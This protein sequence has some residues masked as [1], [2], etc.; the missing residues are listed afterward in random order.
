MKPRIA[1]FFT[2]GT[3][4][5]AREA[6]DGSAVPR[7]SGSDIAA[8]IP[9]LSDRFELTAFEFGRFPGPHMTGQRVRELRG[10]IEEALAGDQDGVVVSHGTDTIEETA[11]SLDL[12]HRSEKPAVVVGAMRTKD[13]PSWDGP[14]NLL[15]ACLTAGSDVAKNLGTLIV[16]NRTIHAASEAT[17]T[18]TGSLDA[19]VSPECGPLG[20]VDLDRAILHRRPIRR[21]VL[22]DTAGAAEPQPV[23]M[24]SAHCD[25]DGRIVDASVELGFRGIVVQAMGR[26]NVPPRMFEALKRAIDRGVCVSICSRC[27]GGRTAPLYGYDGGGASLRDA[28]AIFSPTLGGVKTRIALGYLLADGRNRDEI[29]RFF[30]TGSAS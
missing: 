28:G 24:L 13:E 11:F 10:A 4:G 29:A 9:E 30:E 27:W 18:H 3:I 26:G 15:D 8:S 12:F 7:L 17:K 6:P 14:I 1:I 21:Y 23:E 20:E 22:P 25:S 16:K 5:M 2:G 19:F